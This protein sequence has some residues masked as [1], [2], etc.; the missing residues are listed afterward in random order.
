ML[1]SNLL[2]LILSTSGAKAGMP[3]IEPSGAHFVDFW[4]QG[5]KIAFLDQNHC[6]FKHFLK[7][8]WKNH[9]FS[10]FFIKMWSKKLEKYSV[11]KL[12]D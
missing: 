2:E 5:L 12:F 4:S 8:S 11:F 3:Q 10:Y 7:E 6:V 9:M 1:K